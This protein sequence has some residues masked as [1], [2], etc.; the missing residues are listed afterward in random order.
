MGMTQIGSF[1]AFT[2][3]EMSY[4]QLTPKNLR[5]SRDPDHAPFWTFS[6]VLPGQ[7]LGHACQILS[8]WL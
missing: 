4:Q 1:V 6:G 7:F 5:K 8:P 3:F 2:I